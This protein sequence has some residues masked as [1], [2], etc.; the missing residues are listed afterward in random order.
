MIIVNPYQWRAV[1]LVLLFLVDLLQGADLRQIN[2]SAEIPE[3]LLNSY[4]KN[5]EY[6]FLWHSINFFLHCEDNKYYHI[7]TLACTEILK[8]IYITLGG[9]GCKLTRW[10]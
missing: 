1:L 7:I 5:I 4:V 10:E 9:G 8:A 2:S 6:I 3:K